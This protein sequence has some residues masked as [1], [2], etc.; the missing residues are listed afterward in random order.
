MASFIGNLFD[1]TDMPPYQIPLGSR[2]YGEAGGDAATRSK[3]YDA[4]K[5]I[6]IANF[7]RKGRASRGEEVPQDVLRVAALRQSANTIQKNVKNLQDMRR[8]AQSR[9]ERK[10]LD[11]EIVARQRMMVERYRA[12]AGG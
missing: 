8:E 5:D 10:R 1:G 3:Y 9:E 11:Q 12:V 2:F 7:Q 4:I 6:N